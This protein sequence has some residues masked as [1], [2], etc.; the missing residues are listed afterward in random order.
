MYKRYVKKILDVSF[1]FLLI[2]ILLPLMILIAVAIKIDSP[3]PIIFR[4]NR[5]GKNKK[6]FSI[7]KFRTMKIETP[8]NVPTH[9]LKNSK[10]YLTLVGKFLRITSLDELPQLFNIL[11]GQMSF[12]GPRPALWNQFDLIEAR[13]K[14][15][16]NKI[17]PG[18]S[19]LAQINGR[20]ELDIKTKV[21]YDSEYV[22]KISFFLDTKIF[23]LT[24]INVFL[25]RNIKEGK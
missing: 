1:S 13:E 11:K 9:L 19:G 5:I 14:H 16:V 22:Q 6:M 7:F 2:I 12:I 8:K 15:G 17:Y 4:Q 20:D 18:L 10:M 23:F 25:Q 21:K 24:I 3:G